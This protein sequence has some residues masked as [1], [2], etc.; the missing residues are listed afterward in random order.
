MSIPSLS[1]SDCFLQEQQETK[2]DVAIML[3]KCSIIFMEGVPKTNDELLK[4]DSSILLN[5]CHKIN[6][7]HN[8]WLSI[9][10]KTQ[11]K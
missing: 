10:K 1:S 7:L 11:L 6:R 3:T 9:C 5:E 2:H 8:E 4:A